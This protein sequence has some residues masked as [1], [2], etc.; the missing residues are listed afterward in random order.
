MRSLEKKQS[1]S[2]AWNYLELIPVFILVLRRDETVEFINKKGCEILGH[3][4]EFIIEKNWFDSF[5]PPETQATDKYNYARS[6]DKQFLQESYENSVMTSEGQKRN[7]SWHASFIRDTAGNIQALIAAGEDITEKLIYKKF[8]RRQQNQHNQ[9]VLSAVVDAQEK[10]RTEIAG[11]LHGNVNQILT[12]CKL[13]LE[14]EKA[15]QP[16]SI[17]LSNV[18]EYLQNAIDEIRNLSHRLDATQVRDLGLVLTIQGLIEKISLARKYDLQFILEDDDEDLSSLDERVAL[19]IYRI[20]QEQISNIMKHAEALKIIISLSCSNTSI[21]LE[22]TD[23]GKGF[24]LKTDRRGLGLR[25][26]YGRVALHKGTVSIHTAPGEGC[27][28][29]VCIPRR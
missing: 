2:V 25:N 4:K 21:D 19:S 17:V 11:E 13:L 14:S 18:Y 9:M 3:S 26:I 27:I 8:Q 24:D 15:K 5:I 22:I 20:V 28:L 1:Y 12:T 6:V 10:E 7:I 16:E 29:S 23:D